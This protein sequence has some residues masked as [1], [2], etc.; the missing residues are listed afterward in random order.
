MPLA[1]LACLDQHSYSMSGSVSACIGDHFRILAPN[2]APRSS[3]PRCP[4]MG[5]HNEYPA[6]A[7]AVNRHHRVIY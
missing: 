1:G 2:Q 5:S 3:Q 6:K 7:G 4:S